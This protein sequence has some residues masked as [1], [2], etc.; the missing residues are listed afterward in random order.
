[1]LRRHLAAAP[2]A[3]ILAVPAGGCGRQYES[4]PK[5]LLTEA[6]RAVDATPALHF[7]LSSEN[8]DGADTSITGGEGDARR[9]DGFTGSFA[10]SFHGLTINL[11]VA[12]VGGSFYV[13]LPTGTGYDKVNP[14]DYGF[15][16]PG[17]LIDPDHG[18]VSLLARARTATLDD[19]DRYEGEELYEVHVTVPGQLVKELL[20]SADPSKDV[21]GEVGID[22]DNHE[23]RRVRLVGPFF[24]RGQDATFTVILTDY[25]ENVTVTP[26][27]H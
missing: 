8:A 17:R 18:L 12:S 4:D 16:D 5:L 21:D 25:G 24:A 19:R 1:M 10:I 13:R 22:V 14:A 3:V 11:A 15:S 27:A 7:R 2:L 26:P 6:T 20:T 23:V 9:P